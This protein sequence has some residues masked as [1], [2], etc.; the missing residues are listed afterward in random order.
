[1]SNQDEKKLETK[2]SFPR[3]YVKLNP[4]VAFK[5]RCAGYSYQK[6]ANITGV[7]KSTVINKIKR[8]E[9]YLNDP[10]LEVYEKNKSLVL[11]AAEKKLIEAILSDKKV[12]KANL[13]SL[14]YAFTQVYNANRLQQGL[15]TQNISYEDIAREKERIQKAIEEY[16]ARLKATEIK[17]EVVEVSDAD[18]SQ[19]EN[20]E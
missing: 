9:K 6:I 12:K 14:A 1:M 20:F 19:H 13:S 7:R 2:T 4:A 5:L 10:D 8:I 3:R 18:N 16:E 17:A 15:S 11:S